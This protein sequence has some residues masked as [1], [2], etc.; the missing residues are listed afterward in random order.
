MLTVEVHDAVLD[1]QLCQTLVK[2]RTRDMFNIIPYPRTGV[3]R[4]VPHRRNLILASD[5]S[6][7]PFTGQGRMF[8]PLLSHPLIVCLI[9]SL[10]D[11]SPGRRCDRGKSG[12]T[13]SI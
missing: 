4:D 7:L 10:L 9:D 11:L 6:R 13:R 12:C 5:E 8:E 1:H 3:L 2:E